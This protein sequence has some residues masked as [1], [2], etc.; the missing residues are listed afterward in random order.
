MNLL[1]PML[2]LVQKRL[3]KEVEVSYNFLKNK[4][5]DENILIKVQL[6]EIN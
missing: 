6:I 1:V 2:N 4:N 3:K 5:K